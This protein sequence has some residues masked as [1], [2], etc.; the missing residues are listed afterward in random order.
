MNQT[1]E[2]DYSFKIPFYKHSI[3]P[4][5]IKNSEGL[6]VGNLQRTYNNLSDRVIDAFL[7]LANKKNF[8]V[9]LYGNPEY[10]FSAS[11][12]KYKESLFRDKWTIHIS[13][14]GNLQNIGLFI[15]KSK[16]NTNPRFE[17]TKNNQI[18]IFKK[19]L[20]DKN[21]YVEDKSKK[22]IARIFY[23]KITSIRN[24]YIHI[25]KENVLNHAELLLLAFI[26]RSITD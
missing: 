23:E 21:I 19:D 7:S 26:F 20:L 25:Q 12:V 24:T 10:S 6:T 1:Q 14:K 18:F 17:Y 16:I 5:N 11:F 13:E 22:L 2:Y 9:K 8:K 4:I 15:N 3:L